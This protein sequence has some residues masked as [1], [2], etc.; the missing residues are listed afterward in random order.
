MNI[1]EIHTKYESRIR[2]AVEELNDDGDYNNDGIIVLVKLNYNSSE[3]DNVLD[4]LEADGMAT[5]DYD[6]EGGWRLVGFYG[7]LNEDEVLKRF[8]GVAEAAKI[9]S[10]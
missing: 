9:I 8:S 1:E 7:K 3:Y 5:G 10:V 6:S 2:I 4:D